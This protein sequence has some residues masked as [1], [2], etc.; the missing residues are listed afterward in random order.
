MTPAE[1]KIRAI[2][3][4]TLNFTLPMPFDQKKRYDKLIKQS[5][6]KN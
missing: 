4:A 6:E 5:N 3:K 2:K 1:I